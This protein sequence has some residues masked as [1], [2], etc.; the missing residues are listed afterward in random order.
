[1]VGCLIQGLEFHSRLLLPK[2][3]IAVFSTAALKCTDFFFF[4]FVIKHTFRLGKNITVQLTGAVTNIYYF[5]QTQQGK[6]ECNAI[7]LNKGVIT[8]DPYSNLSIFIFF[9]GFQCYHFR[10][11]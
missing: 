7:A 9:N 10:H 5:G 2:F 4:S 1:M 8:F 11:L 3:G 6:D